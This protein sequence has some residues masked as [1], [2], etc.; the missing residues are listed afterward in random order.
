[1]FRA[2]FFVLLTLLPAAPPLAGQVPEKFENLK[3]LPPDVSKQDLIDRMRQMT[4]ALGARCH[5]CHVGE[6]GTRLQGYD[7]ASDEKATKR[8]ARVMMRMVDQ[9]NGELLPRIGKERAALV[10]VRCVTCHRGQSR[11]RS[12]EDVLAEVVASEGVEA[13]VA[14]YRELRERYYGGHSFDFR[15]WSL[16]NLAE[17]LADQGKLDAA[18]RFIELNLEHYPDHGMSYFTRGQLQQRQG[19]VEK[20]IASYRK[21]AEL[22]P[23]MAPRIRET[24][25]ELLA[26]EA[27]GGLRPHSS[28]TPQYR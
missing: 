3:V 5:F 7:F 24:I 12:L 22:M 6:P 19:A 2:L 11:P 13:A 17:R 18:D 9:I 1:M 20:A 21:A 14:R 15:H 8:T 4:F 16:L 23:E 28:R 25:D 10:E 27:R 26:T